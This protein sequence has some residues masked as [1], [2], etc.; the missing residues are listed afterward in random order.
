MPLEAGTIC[1]NFVPSASAWMARALQVGQT[2]EVANLEN[3][4][5][6]LSLGENPF[7]KVPNIVLI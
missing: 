1:C 2:W 5:G 4:L 3:T 6:K 7:V